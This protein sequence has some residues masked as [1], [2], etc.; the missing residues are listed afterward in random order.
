MRWR[1][2]H[3]KYP[4]QVVGIRQAENFR[5]VGPG[6]VACNAEDRAGLARLFDEHQFA[7]VL[8]C[9]GNCA[10]KQCEVAPEIGVADQR[11][12]RAEPALADRAA[13]RAAGA[14]F[15]RSGV[16]RGRRPRRLRRDRSDRPGDGLRPDDGGRRRGRSWRP[17]RRPASCGFRCRWA[18][19]SAA[20]PGRST[21]SSSRF[22]KSR[23]ATLYFDEIRTPT[24]TDCLNRLCERCSPAS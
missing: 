16:F 14:S 5:L 2:S 6:V 18:S 7:A 4:G 13:R 21:G 24:Y 17:T 1:I 12:R 9:A 20:M 15:V 19:V 11:R 22:K 10:L 8:D 23:P 3:A